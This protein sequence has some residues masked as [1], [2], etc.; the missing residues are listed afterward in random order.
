MTSI[1]IEVEVQLGASIEDA[2]R[3]T[4]ALA[5]ALMIEVRFKFNDVTV[6]ARPGAD[7]ARLVAAWSD[8]MRSARQC[9]FATD[10]ER[11]ANG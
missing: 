5:D 9:K 6:L 8:A 4:I 10:G 7:P 3:E 1:S 2:C 11:N